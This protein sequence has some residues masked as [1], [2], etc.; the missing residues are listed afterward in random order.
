MWKISCRVPLVFVISGCT[1]WLQSRWKKNINPG[2]GQPST[3]ETTACR[4]SDEGWKYQLTWLEPRRPQSAQR[5][6]TRSLSPPPC[7]QKGDICFATLFCRHVWT[8]LCSTAPLQMFLFH[9]PHIVMSTTMMLLMI[10]AHALFIPCLFFSHSIEWII[11]YAMCLLSVER[12]LVIYSPQQLQ[13]LVH[14]LCAVTYFFLSLSLE[15]HLSQCPGWHRMWRC[16]WTHWW[17]TRHERGQFLQRLCW[18]RG[19]LWDPQR[20]CKASSCWE[21]SSISR[22]TCDETHGNQRAR[23]RP[24]ESFA[25]LEPPRTTAQ[26]FTSQRTRMG[27]RTWQARTRC[28][29]FVVP[30]RA[31]TR[32]SPLPGC[33]SGRPVARTSST[34]DGERGRLLP[35]ATPRRKLASRHTMQRSLTRGIFHRPNRQTWWDLEFFTAFIRKCWAYRVMLTM[36]KTI[37]REIDWTV[38]GWDTGRQRHWDKT[39]TEKPYQ[40]PSRIVVLLERSSLREQIQLNVLH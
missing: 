37:A 10:V 40:L 24:V 36:M 13:M 30:E 32:W 2:L 21:V 8:C 6:M 26:P 1:C 22:W 39:Q 4:W 11:T 18:I 5:C 34:L 25:D 19:L 28:V 33:S 12:Q 3:T 17:P 15:R 9:N 35:W 7:L 27:R 20:V 31:H 16:I 29:Q 23:W 38:S 14:D